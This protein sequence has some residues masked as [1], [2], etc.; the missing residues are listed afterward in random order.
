MK[1]PFE[2]SPQDIFRAFRQFPSNSVRRH[3]STP[4]RE[5]SKNQGGVISGIREMDQWS[6]PTWEKV[7]G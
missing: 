1:D 4:S 2:E 7:G 6:N 5:V 3:G